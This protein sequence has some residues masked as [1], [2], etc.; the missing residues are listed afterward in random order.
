M[1]GVVFGMMMA[2]LSMI[3]MVAA[4]VGSKSNIVG[5]VLHL[6]ISVFIGITFAFL[7]QDKLKSVGSGLTVGL[8]YGVFWWVL[9]ALVLLPAKLHMPLFNFNTAT[10][11]SLMGHMVFG[12]I[13]GSLVVLIPS[14]MH[15]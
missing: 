5:W 4:L 14:K 11:E 7:F 15:K 13:L 8:G 12:A 6:G 9:G 3:G 2:M 10:W 1:G